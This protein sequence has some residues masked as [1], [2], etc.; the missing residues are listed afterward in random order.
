MKKIVFSFLFTFALIGAYAQTAAT[1][2][3]STVYKEYVGKYV[4]KDAMIQSVIVNFKDGKLTGDSEQ[5]SAELLPINVTS[6]TNEIFEVAGFDGT[7]QFIRDDNGKVVKIIL[8][9][10]GTTMEG[11]KEE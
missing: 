7:N 9:V 5:G 11:T 1:A 3:D 8:K 4:F 6:K 2:L 10:Q